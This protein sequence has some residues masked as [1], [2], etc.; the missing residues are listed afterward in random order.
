MN[1]N[2]AHLALIY[3]ALQ[4]FTT[5]MTAQNIPNGGFE[6]VVIDTVFPSNTRPINW[7]PF[8]WLP[9]V[10]CWPFLEQQGTISHDSNTGQFAIKMETQGCEAPPNGYQHR[11]SGFFTGNPGMFAPEGWALIYDQR[12]EKLNFF[13]KFH[14]ESSDS[15]FVSV[16]LFNYDSLTPNIPSAQRTDTIGFGF[17]YIDEPTDVYT[18]YTLPINYFS[19]SVPSFINIVFGSGYKCTL[20][21]CTPGT[22]LW[23]DDVSVSGGTLGLTDRKR[24]KTQFSIY[25]N[26]STHSFRIQSKDPMNIARVT[27]LNYLGQELKVWNGIEE[28]F[29][30]E[31]HPVGTYLIRIETGQGLAVE[32]LMKVN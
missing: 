12:P 17:G 4:Y 28:E 8:H 13:Y 11:A 16:M 15:A 19:D 29:S 7:M 20:S 24:E 18:A 1:T 26:P 27:L 23:V 31:G 2:I 3:I 22:T 30:I 32:K 25:P 9:N 10:E 6:E 21:N 5:A 14:Q